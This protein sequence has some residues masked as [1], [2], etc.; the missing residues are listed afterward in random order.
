MGSAPMRI[1]AGSSSASNVLMASVGE[2][3]HIL[4]VSKGLMGACEN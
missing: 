4:I 2:Y 1:L 3:A